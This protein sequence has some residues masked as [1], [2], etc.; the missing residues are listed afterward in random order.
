MR[1]G[2][3][4]VYPDE[5]GRWDAEILQISVYRGKKNNLNIMKNCVSMCRELGIRYVTH[6]IEYSI[7]DRENFSEIKLMAENTDL[8]L[9]LHDEKN[10][11]RSR[12]TGNYGQ[13]FSKLIE[14]LISITC[15]SFENATDTGDV[16]WF[17]ENYADSVTL[18]IGHIESS[19]INSVEFIKSLDNTV[20]K[21]IQYVHI[22]RN[23]GLHEGITDHWPLHP[24]CRELKALREL[25]L[26]K[27]DIG[28]I[29]EINDPN[30]IE[31]NLQLLKTLKDEL[32]I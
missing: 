22:H 1:V 19:G 24:N 15:V 23:N 6:P 21:K 8:A 30:M 29:L 31:D 27:S 17:W 13:I 14:E 26:K 25:L 10:P 11:D 2:T 7:L 28:V 16:L 20:I 12:L 5:A 3:R 4:I 32:G 18:D 9:I